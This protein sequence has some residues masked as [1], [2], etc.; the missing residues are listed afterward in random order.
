MRLFKLLTLLAFMG[1][2]PAL[3]DQLPST[4]STIST[5]TTSTSTTGGNTFGSQVQQE[6]S[7]AIK[8][9]QNVNYQK[10]SAAEDQGQFSSDDSNPPDSSHLFNIFSG[11]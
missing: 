10:L 9:F 1:I 6:T 3:A 5:G 2:Q 8:T 11:S 4:S 7:Q